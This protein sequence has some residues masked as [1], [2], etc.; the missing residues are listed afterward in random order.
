MSPQILSIK[1]EAAIGA[2][3]TNWSPNRVAAKSEVILCKPSD[4]AD[5]YEDFVARAETS[6]I[7]KHVDIDQEGPGLV[8]LQEPMTSEQLLA[9]H[10]RDATATWTQAFR[11]NPG[12]AGPRPEL[13]EDLTDAQWNRIARLQAEYKVKMVTYSNH[14][15]A[16]TDL[17]AWVRSTVD[18]TYLGN[19]SS[20]SNLRTIVRELKSSLA[21]TDTEQF[22]EAR[23][24]YRQVLGQTKRVKPEDWLVAWNKARLEGERRKIPELQG[25][26]GISDFLTAVTTFD[27]VVFRADLLNLASEPGTRGFRSQKRRLCVA[28]SI[29]STASTSQSA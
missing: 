13:A 5:W 7:L 24:K 4:W 15:R 17:A 25:H 12:T 20:K 22:D 28:T 1:H 14:Q 6:K 18:K 26:A 2:R 9:K 29:V 10:L 11:V 19:T 8:E 21:P 16:Y 3:V 23:L 27:P